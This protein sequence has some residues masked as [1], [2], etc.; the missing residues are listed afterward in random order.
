V[1]TPGELATF[2]EATPFDYLFSIGNFQILK[3]E[4]LRAPRRLAINF[5]DSPL[6]RYRGLHTTTWA[7]L[8]GET[9]HGVTWH[10]MTDEIDAGEVL[11]EE[12]IEIS[13][14]ETSFTLNAKCFEAGLKSFTRLVGLLEDADVRPPRPTQRGPLYLRH[15]RPKDGCLLSFAKPARE[16]ERMVRALDWGPY[17]NPF[18]AARLCMNG[19]ALVVTSARAL[20]GSRELTP[21]TIVD[22][23]SGGLTVAT[24]DGA[25]LLESFATLT[26]EAISVPDV[27]ER[28]GLKVGS[29]L[30][31][32][33]E[34]VR[35]R[36]GQALDLAVRNEAFWVERL[37]SLRPLELP[38][39]GVRDRGGRKPERLAIVVPEDYLVRLEAMTSLSRA[40]LLEIALLAYFARVTAMPKFDVGFASAAARSLGGLP[41]LLAGI[42]PC[43][44]ACDLDQP[45]LTTLEELATELD[46]V[47]E[48]FSYPLDALLR[49]PALKNVRGGRHVPPIV[50]SEVAH[51]CEAA[52][53]PGAALT[54]SID[55]GGAG[56]I[57]S[58]E[59][60]TIDGVSLKALA[61]QLPEF[62]RAIAMRPDA[63]LRD[64]PITSHAE[65]R[66]IVHEWNPASLP[67][68]S[69]GSV[70]ELIERQA[71]ATPKATAVIADDMVLTFAELDARATGLAGALR[72]A[73]VKP[74]DRVAVCLRRQSPLIVTLLAVWKA[75]AAYVPLD[76]LNPPDRLAFMLEDSGAALLV[77]ES[78]MAG[79]LPAFAGPT[80][81]VDGGT[82]APHSGR[83]SA[84]ESSGEHLAY[85]IYTS[86]STGRPKG[87]MVTHANVLSFFAGMD[88][89]LEADG[90]GTWL[91]V[92]SVSFDISV[93]E[94]WWTLA[95]GFNVVIHGEERPL[96]LGAKR[97]EKPITFSLAYFSSDSGRTD[98]NRYRLL[99]EGARFADRHGFTAV[100]TPERHF[101]AF[102]GLYPNPS[103][104]SAAVA[105][106][107][108]R[109]QIRAG[110]VVLPLHN[111]VR[112]AEEWAVVDNLSNGRV[113]VSFASGWQP[114]DFVL[115]PDKYADR[116]EILVRDLGIV[117]KLWRGEAVSLPGPDGRAVDVKSLPRPIQAELP[118]WIT[119]AGN[120]ETF[121]L[122]GEQGANL[123]T[124]LL[125]QDP[126]ELAP[127]I[128]LY[129]QAWRDAGHGPGDGHVTV[130]LHTFIGTDSERVRGQVRPS[131][132][133]YLK[134]S[135]DL[136]KNAP[137][138]F[139]AWSPSGTAGAS[140]TAAT[141]N[142][143]RTPD[144]DALVEHAFQRY[145]DT[146]GLFG[147]PATALER[148]ARLQDLGVDEIACLIDFGLPDDVVLDGLERLLELKRRS[149]V[150]FS[151]AGR[152]IAR[153]IVQ[154]GVSHLQC[155]P[156][157]AS[158]LVNDSETRSALRRL[159]TLFVGGEQLNPGLADDLRSLVPGR[160][161]NMYGPTETTVWSTADVLANDGG[162][163]IGRPLAN[164]RV[165]ILNDR[166]EAVPAGVPGEI[167]IGGQGVARGYWNRADLT[168]AKFVPD[169]FDA[170]NGTVYRTGDLGRYL[171][172]GRLEFLG[173]KD[174]QV[175]IRGMRVE[176]EE[177]EQVLTSYDEVLEA[178]VVP[179]TAPDGT[180]R[181]DA[182][183]VP[184][185][186][187]LDENVLRTGLAARLP[188]YM[189]PATITVLDALPKTSGGKVDRGAL[190]L[191]ESF[192]SRSVPALIAPDGPVE[193]ALRELWS[194]LLRTAS[195]GAEDDFFTL[196]GHS[197]LAIQLCSRVRDIFR[198]DLP[199]QVLF[200]ERTIRRLARALE[201]LETTPG[202][203]ERI[204]R[205]F[206]TVAS[207][208]DDEVAGA[209]EGGNVSPSSGASTVE[210]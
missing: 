201:L 36:L 29:T 38:L 159:R 30:A 110:S 207:L 83:E 46:Q 129:R 92:T 81:L 52:G 177:I 17:Q 108:E 109:I 181:V 66:R 173:R 41:R 167:V 113:G 185:G 166:L 48:R 161:V 97:S 114:N 14:R 124:H 147:T 65:R 96:T 152:S 24:A 180:I 84:P 71:A 80:F 51:L 190:P 18:G 33:S 100:W 12:P 98:R 196:G 125:G 72:S 170:A 74:R 127:K 68:R 197:L 105:A 210:V 21:G 35:E 61:D 172:D 118:V 50:V 79:R 39:A 120:P 163:T 122:A 168:A 164:T 86:G 62:C 153:E 106:V 140:N 169:P 209:L 165:Y 200:E 112:I 187:A 58:F 77:T 49:Y 56:Y 135:V 20:D 186:P 19:G 199:L 102:G 43:R 116:R 94:M 179:R 202:L 47:S 145:H 191:V 137:S 101:H 182:Y 107:T 176:P 34:T 13:S 183:V 88:R 128:A 28:Y 8:N 73:G 93:L 134:S 76:P 171:E 184:A 2:G 188:E 37:A 148:V 5:H 57:W 16:T 193:E 69:G 155:T 208:T 142:E 44:A 70:H 4:V 10:V 157:L 67:E 45:F 87:V 146:S 40:R 75:G 42:V 194:E 133:A 27:A 162:A 158:A 178:A 95:R 15:S 59:S 117:K 144:L 1:A 203:V 11:E 189:V 115:A 151:A 82:G 195:I 119:A 6:Q 149:D 156:S 175:K 131:L 104:T 85:V 205:L 7:L 53:V 103:L 32:P 174:R 78:G 138:S 198:I 111:P 132:S 91:A 22:V 60:D 25:L 90:L 160:V 99:L 192:R 150:R 139:P 55:D 123:L 126:E 9:R 64:L 23:G 121:R 136:I 3:A 89:H 63:R 31:E 54:V 154:Y 130:M 204:A 206:V 141:F 143:L 26:G